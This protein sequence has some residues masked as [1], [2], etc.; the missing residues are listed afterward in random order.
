MKHRALVRSLVILAA[1]LLMPLLFKGI[2]EVGL[3]NLTRN[4]PRLTDSEIRELVQIGMSK[5]TVQER[6]GEPKT[7]GDGGR[8]WIYLNRNPD[9]GDDV[10]RG[11]SIRFEND[12]VAR[13]SLES[14]AQK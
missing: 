7:K 12:L 3:W 6:L 14:P 4:D 1:L 10:S 11:F 13:I 2:K 8:V 5:D 9:P